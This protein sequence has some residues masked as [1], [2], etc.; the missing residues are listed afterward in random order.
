KLSLLQ[1]GHIHERDHQTV[2]HVLDSTIGPHPHE[3]PGACLRVYLP[4]LCDQDLE[5]LLRIVL[6]ADVFQADHDVT[7]RPP[8][9][10][11]NEID[12]MSHRRGQTFDVQVVIQDD[13]GQLGAVLQIYHLV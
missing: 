10:R 3:I 12:H 7:E 6:Q 9:I 8:D 4:V 13:H 1:L 2:D 5:D 11:R